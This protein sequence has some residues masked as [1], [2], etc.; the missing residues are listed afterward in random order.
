MKVLYYVA[1]LIIVLLA[2]SSG[3]AKIMLVEQEV[4]TFG[5]VGFSNPLLIAFGCTQLI[6]A[7]LFLM[8]KLKK[9]GGC[10]LGITFL[11]SAIVLF[12]LNNVVLGVITLV[13]LGVIYQ[14]SFRI[15]HR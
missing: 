13:V 1:T 4:S 10:I 3:I 11:T 15:P 12:L 5:Q 9:I 8:P 6:G 14:T 2:V 7:I